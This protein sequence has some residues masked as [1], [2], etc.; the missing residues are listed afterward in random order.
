MNTVE[1]WKPDWAKI[2]GAQYTRDVKDGTLTFHKVAAHFEQ[3]L[4]RDA[5]VNKGP[6]AKGAFGPTFNGEG[7]DKGGTEKNNSPSKKRSRPV[8]IQAKCIIC[9]RT[10]C[11]S[12]ERCYYAFPEK[13]PI[14]WN[15][16]N[17]I[18]EVVNKNL[19]KKHVKDKIAEIKAK[20]RKAA[21][22]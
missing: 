14:E 9:K 20:R 17:H 1:R 2:Y 16:K 7:S 3:E 21:Q 8:S 12:L 18:Q 5:K 19:Q 13:A 4:I 15:A 6:V 10:K 22:E 11:R